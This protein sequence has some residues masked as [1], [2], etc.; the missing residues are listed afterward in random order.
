MWNFVFEN[1][2]AAP[3]VPSQLAEES[4]VLMQI[5]AK[6]SENEIR[7]KRSFEFFEGVFDFDRCIRE[8]AIAKRF[9]DDIL[10]G[11]VA[12]KP[13]SAFLSFPGAKRI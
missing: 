13:G 9:N 11:R 7:L 5:L 4:M 1:E 10:F 3:G 8:K 2:V 6:M 12:Q